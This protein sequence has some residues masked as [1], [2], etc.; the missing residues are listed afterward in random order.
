MSDKAVYRT[1]LAT[2]GLLINIAGTLCSALLIEAGF[3]KVH[4][5]KYGN[6]H[7]GVGKKEWI[8]SRGKAFLKLIRLVCHT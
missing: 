7:F 1:A 3:G 8:L 6:V 2:P 4:V 5:Q